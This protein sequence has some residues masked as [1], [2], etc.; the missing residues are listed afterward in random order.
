MEDKYVESK[1]NSVDLLYKTIFEV[2]VN[3][4]W[5]GL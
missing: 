3:R 2:A 1:D 5:L 4:Y